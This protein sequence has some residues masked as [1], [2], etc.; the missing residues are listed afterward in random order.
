MLIV[1]TEISTKNGNPNFR[2]VIVVKKSKIQSKFWAWNPASKMDWKIQSI[3][4]FPKDLKSKSN[5]SPS[6]GEKVTQVNGS[7]FQISDCLHTGLFVAPYILDDKITYWLA[8]SATSL[9]RCGRCA[10]AESKNGT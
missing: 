3:P 10:M 9:C 6:P 1:F 4:H 7:Y 5:P 8:K 2:T